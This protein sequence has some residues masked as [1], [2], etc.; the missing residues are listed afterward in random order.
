MTPNMVIFFYS[1][2]YWR[3]VSWKSL[4]AFSRASWHAQLLAHLIA[5]CTN[6]DVFRWIR[7]YINILFWIDYTFNWIIMLNMG[8]LWPLQHSSQISAYKMKLS[9]IFFDVKRKW[10]KF[11][12]MNIE[13]NTSKGNFL[14]FL[15][16]STIK[17]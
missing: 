7:S 2:K 16:C 1:N 6:L 11:E 9:N 13:A 15:Q 3:Q 4:N 5:W 14:F 12:D 10:M 17:F 8:E